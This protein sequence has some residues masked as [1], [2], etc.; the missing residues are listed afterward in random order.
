MGVVHLI[1]V[2]MMKQRASIDSLFC[3]YVGDDEVYSCQPRVS[4]DDPAKA[5]HPVLLADAIEFHH[6]PI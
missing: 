6:I 3:D 4:G 1:N 5:P 2:A